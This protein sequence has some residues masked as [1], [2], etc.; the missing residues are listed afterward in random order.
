MLA[1]VA[2]EHD[3]LKG[4]GIASEHARQCGHAASTAPAVPDALRGGSA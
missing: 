1:A 4:L 3:A 2:R